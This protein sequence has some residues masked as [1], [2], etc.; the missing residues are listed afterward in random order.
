MPVEI[1]VAV[2]DVADYFAQPREIIRFVDEHVGAFEDGRVD[3]VPD[4][5]A[6]RHV[7]QVHRE[8]EMKELAV[9]GAHRHRGGARRDGDPERPQHTAAV[10]L[11][12]VLPA[13]VQPQFA[14]AVTVDQVT[15]RPGEGLRLRGG[16]G[17]R[18]D[19]DLVERQRERQ[20]GSGEQRAPG[21]AQSSLSGRVPCIIVVPPKS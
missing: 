15:P 5:Q 4:D 7:R 8:F 20:N 9:Q 1:P 3:Q 10:A 17:E 14:S 19:D 21:F 11:L 2:D 6:Q 13:Q 12:D 16:V 18:G